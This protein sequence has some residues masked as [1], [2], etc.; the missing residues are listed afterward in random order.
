MKASHLLKKFKL[1]SLSRDVIIGVL[2]TALLGINL[3]ISGISLRLDLSRGKAY[4]L[5]ESSAKILRDLK[6]PVELVFFVSEDLP[7]SF[8][9]TKNQGSVKINRADCLLYH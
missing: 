9:T 4:S 1:D 6:D 3:L 7:T 8:I 2:L 5:S